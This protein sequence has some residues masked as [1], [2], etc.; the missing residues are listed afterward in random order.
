MFCLLVVVVEEECSIS[1]LKI[2][3]RVFAVFVPFFICFF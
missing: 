2:V 3:L 1:I